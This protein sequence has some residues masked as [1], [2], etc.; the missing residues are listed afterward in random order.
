MHV[1]VFDLTRSCGCGKKKLSPVSGND[2]TM[3][4]GLYGE[5]EDSDPGVGGRPP[6]GLTME[7]LTDHWDATIIEGPLEEFAVDRSMGVTTFTKGLPVM[8]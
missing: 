5:A 4:W 8:D 3:R 7:L 6:G 1:N 2:Y